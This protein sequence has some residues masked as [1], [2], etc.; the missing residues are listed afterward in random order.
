MGEHVDI[1]TTPRPRFGRRQVTPHACIVD[2]KPHLRAFLAETLVEFGLVPR[3]AA[4]AAGVL[5]MN[6]EIPSDLVVY[7]LP[8]ASAD[9]EAF[10]RKL[11]AAQYEGR[12]L[13]LG[14]ERSTALGEAQRC[15]ARLGLTM[16]PALETPFRVEELAERVRALDGVNMPLEAPVDVSEAL[17]HDWLEVWYQPKIDAGTLIARGAEAL[18][19]MRHPIW[20]VVL[21]ASFIPAY[22][23]PHLRHLSEFVVSRVCA[24]RLYFSDWRPI[25]IAVNLPN[26]LLH[27]EDFCDVLRKAAAGS[28]GAGTLILEINSGEIIRDLP[29]AQAAAEKLRLDGIQ[30]AIDGVGP[31]WPMLTGLSD[32]P[33]AEIKV[34]PAF[35]QGC[36]TDGP[37]RAAC[38][39]IVEFAK[40]AGVRTVAHGVENRADLNAVR[41]M[42][43]DLVQ[44]F[45]FAKPMEARKFARSLNKR[46]GRRAPPPEAASDDQDEVSCVSIA[47]TSAGA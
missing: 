44:G 36:A 20:G 28:A 14:A 39:A 2:R 42:G 43:F 22:G 19:R 37:K 31:E 29:F 33:F 11:A 9:A 30:L 38:G 18:C 35:I 23:D 45:L 41:A 34:G 6:A 27:D 10:L 26:T 3:Q 5:A 25:D 32:F 40:Q 46:Q 12:V 17:A 7:S 16:L 21:P 47:Q 13:L 1:A 24:D 4:D 8:P 15:G